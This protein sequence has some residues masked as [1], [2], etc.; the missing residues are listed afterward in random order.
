MSNKTKKC[1]ICKDI[2]NYD[3]YY[4][5]PNGT[6]YSQCNVCKKESSKKWYKKDMENEEKYNKEGKICPQCKIYKLKDCFYILNKNG[7]MSTYC[8]E[9]EAVNNLQNPNRKLTKKKWISNNK[10]KIRKSQLE[11]HHNKR[12]HNIQY[13]LSQSLRAEMHRVLDKK[14]NSNELL[15]CDIDFFEKWLEFQFNS[16]MNWDNYGKYWEIDHTKPCTSYVLEIHEE[17]LRCFNWKN[18]RPLE[19]EKN[20]SKKDNII[21]LDIIKQTLNV[22]LF[23]R[24]HVQIAGT[25]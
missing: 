21:E 22:I 12:K 10:D 23:K 7:Q 9:C 4:I 18:L 3:H 6:P 24:Q 16:K 17:Q 8:T 25:S 20:R 2:K 14:N 13:R 11:Y 5:R 15:G 1:S 19:V